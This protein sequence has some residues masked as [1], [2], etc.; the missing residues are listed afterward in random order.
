MTQNNSN[1]SHTFH[2]VKRLVKDYLAPHKGRLGMAVFCMII[3]A[4]CTALTAKMIQPILDELLIN[5]NEAL[6][7]IV[8]GLTVLI[9]FIKGVAGYFQNY[10]MEFIGQRMIADLQTNLYKHVIHHDLAF[11]QKETVSGLTSR[12]VFDLHQLKKALS[13]T[14][15]GVLKDVPMI[16]GLIVLMVHQNWKLALICLTIIPLASAPIIYFGRRMRKYSGGTQE[17]MGSLGGIL[18][19]SLGHIRQ[20]KSFT[21]EN[22]EIDRS[23]KSINNV[24]KLLIKM[25]RVRALSSPVM[26]LLGGLI[27]AGVIMYGCSLIW[28]GEMTAGEFMSFLTAAMSIYRPLK[29]VTNINN[30]LQ[31]GLASAER[32]F[33][34]MDSPATITEQEGAA[35]LQVKKGEIE[36]KNITFAYEE[37]QNA[38][39]GLNLTIPAGKK[40]ALVGASGAGKSTILNLIPRFFDPKEGEILIDGQKV[41]NVT[42][43]SLRQNIGLV[44][45]EVALFNDTIANNIAY[46]SQTAN[47]EDIIKAAQDASADGF[48][49]ESENGYDTVV[50]E[51]G[52]SL[53]GGQRQRIAIAR[54]MLKNAP[55]LLLDEATSS[56]DTQSE[57]NIQDALNKLMKGR[58]SLIVAHRLSTTQDAD[59]IHVLDKG[60]VVETGSHQELLEKNGIYANLYKMQQ[61]A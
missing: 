17:E 40:V 26:E 37:G 32:T 22:Y 25:A 47:R 52:F 41:S 12:F 1:N 60:Q 36:F 6:F 27:I 46:G 53:S 59:I 14:I 51:D 45:Q 18:K 28:N 11:L 58:T 29:S 13:N 8:P 9:F 35:E 15:T 20:V 49:T 10:L 50:G 38:I 21:M 33:N 24:F 30:N 48:I 54:A 42:L 57:K 34:L 43:N 44:T 31:E 4:V 3:V 61:Q 16:I 56:L 5:K 7:Y 55:I 39:E 2:L 19:E 23:N